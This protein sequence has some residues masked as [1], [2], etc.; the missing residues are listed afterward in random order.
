MNLFKSLSFWILIFGSGLITS[1]FSTNL[2]FIPVAAIALNLVLENSFINKLGAMLLTAIFLYFQ[3]ALM[4]I[5]LL[6]SA[7]FLAIQLIF[8][9]KL[10]E[11]GLYS[12]ELALSALSLTLIGST[13]PLIT[14]AAV[15]LGIFSIINL[16]FLITSTVIDIFNYVTNTSNNSK[17]FYPDNYSVTLPLT[18]EQQA[19]MDV[20]RSLQV[21]NVPAAPQPPAPLTV[22]PNDAEE[23]YRALQIPPSSRY[24]S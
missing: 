12:S 3:P 8:G 9:N 14:L 21:H 15:V 13:L 22:D 5:T 20:Y 6:M 24:L 23:F 19:N 10:L 7:G 11:F 2:I 16:S 1:I 18:P 4:P 17:D